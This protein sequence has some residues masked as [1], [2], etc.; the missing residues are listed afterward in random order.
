MLSVKNLSVVYGKVVGV[1]DVSIEVPEGA[2]VT[3]IGANGAGKTTILRAISGLKRPAS[4]EIVFDGKRIDRL[5]PEKITRLGIAQIPEGRRVFPQMSAMENL[6]MGAFFR[7][8][9]AGIRRDLDNVFRHFPVLRE[10][11]RQLA[12]TLSGGEQQMLAMG[13]GLMS[14]P[15]VILMDEPSLGLSPIM[16]QTIARIIRDIHAE[17]RTIVLVEQNARLALGLADYGYVLETGR[18]AL[19]G[20]AET[21]KGNEKVQESYLGVA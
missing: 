7:R 15:R 19:S 16:C 9:G 20:A 18:V 2:I 5:S 1:K 12:G 6:E 21:L 8:D 11:R 14:N 4:G 13:R 3:L 10:R 17:G